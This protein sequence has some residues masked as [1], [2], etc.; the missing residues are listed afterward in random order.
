MI[1]FNN[2]SIDFPFKTIIKNTTFDFENNWSLI[3]RNGVGKTQILIK[4]FE[5][6]SLDNK[7]VMMCGVELPSSI[8]SL[9][10]KEY[11]DA[12]FDSKPYIDSFKQE[13][14]FFKLDFSKIYNQSISTLSGGEKRTIQIIMAILGE[15][16]LILLDE[17]EANMDEQKLIILSKRLNKLNTQVIIASHNI[18][19]LNSFIS[20]KAIIDNETISPYSGSIG[21]TSDLIK[22]LSGRK[23]V[24]D[25][26]FKW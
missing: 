23:W 20:K 16:E 2:I 18:V 1:K 19:I 11:F 9:T 7:K 10:I 25:E 22:L 5:I 26:N 13:A 6:T 14:D 8:H 15:F 3:G 21:T 17:P 12:F 4:M 24:I